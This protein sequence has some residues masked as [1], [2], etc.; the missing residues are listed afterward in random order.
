MTLGSHQTTLGKE[1]ARFTPRRILDALGVFATDATAGAPRPWDIGTERNITVAQ[2]CLTMDWRD[3]GRTWLNPPFARY[4]VGEFVRLMCEHDHGIMLLHAR[5]ETEWFRPI[6]RAASG[7]LWLAGRVVF[8]YADGSS[9]R[10][11]N[12]TAKHYGKVANSGAPVVLIAF[13]ASDADALDGCGLDGE[14]QPLIFPRFVLI[15]AIGQ[16]DS[17]RTIVAQWLKHEQGP[18]RVAQLYRAFRHHPK[19]QDNPNWKAKLRQTLQRGAGRSVGR[20]Q[21]MAVG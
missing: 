21:W 10:I 7:L 12:P 3:F 6:W 8:C 9:C 17:W 11:E 1:N 4:G 2:N 5:T 18:V 13:G 15:A 19:V 14:F 20:D 16:T